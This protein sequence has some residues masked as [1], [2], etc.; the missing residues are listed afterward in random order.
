MVNSPS[1]PLE[2]RPWQGPWPQ[3]WCQSSLPFSCVGKKPCIN[4]NKNESCEISGIT[5][6]HCYRF[7]RREIKEN[8]VSNRKPTSKSFDTLFLCCLQVDE[9]AC[10]GGLTF[11]LLCVEVVWER[12]S[13]IDVVRD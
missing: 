12:T 6:R 4:A 7:L 1:S 10:R 8:P 13:G 11:Y 9:E 5:K 2:W 3:P